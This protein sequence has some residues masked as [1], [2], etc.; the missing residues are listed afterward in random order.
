MRRS[1]SVVLMLLLGLQAGMPAAARAENDI[2]S[3]T[4]RISELRTK[5]DS[6][7]GVS[8]KSADKSV[9]PA[10]MATPDKQADKGKSLD[11][12]KIVLLPPTEDLVKKAEHATPEGESTALEHSQ[13]VKMTVLF[14]DAGTPSSTASSGRISGNGASAA[15]SGNSARESTAKALN[16]AA[17]TS[18]TP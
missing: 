12:E 16:S 14:H 1:S 4:Q 10:V 5:L 7:R 6:F 17:A 8:E 13:G 18:K 9:N 2:H 3:I 11:G 15:V